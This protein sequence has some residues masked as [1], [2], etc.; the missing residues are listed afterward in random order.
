M[1]QITVF[2]GPERRR[3][4]SDDCFVSTAEAAQHRWRGVTF[5]VDA[6]SACETN[7]VC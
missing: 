3:Q 2:S 4:W 5:C 1:S 6:Q 7:L